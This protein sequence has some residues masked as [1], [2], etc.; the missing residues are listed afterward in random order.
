MFVGLQLY[1][2]LRIYI[3]IHEEEELSETFVWI[4]WEHNSDEY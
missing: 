3:I 2:Q 4:L 1:K